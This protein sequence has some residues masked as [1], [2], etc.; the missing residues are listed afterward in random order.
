MGFLPLAFS[1]QASYAYAQGSSWK[2]LWSTN[3]GVRTSFDGATYLDLDGNGLVDVLYQITTPIAS[4]TQFDAATYL[5]TGIGW[6]TA[7][8]QSSR[9]D[10]FCTGGNVPNPNCTPS[11]LQ[12]VLMQ[13]SIFTPVQVAEILKVDE[14]QVLELLRSQRLV[15]KQI[16]D[17]WRIHEDA[18]HMFLTTKS[19]MTSFENGDL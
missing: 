9:P 1:Q 7:S 11:K 17:E 10:V 8:C 19:P 6:C 14:T 12:T 2:S 4:G 5:N 18:I 16:E 15:G 13:R 3:D